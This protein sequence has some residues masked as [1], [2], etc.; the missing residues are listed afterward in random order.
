[1]RHYQV[2]VNG[3]NIPV[4]LIAKK[5]SIVE[6]EIDGS[7]YAVDVAPVLKARSQ[8]NGS[9]QPSHGSSGELKAAMPGIIVSIAK[10][11]GDKVSIGETVV[12]IEAMKMENNIAAPKNGIIKSI[13]VKPGQEIESGRLIMVIE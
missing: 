12:V 4:N 2:R 5:G 13:A 6:F 3:K 9:E 1:M 11:V 8:N 10:K 7:N